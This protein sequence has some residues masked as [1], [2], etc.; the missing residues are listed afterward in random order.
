[1]SFKSKTESKGLR[2]ASLTLASTYELY[3]PGITQIPNRP[4]VLPRWS[5][6]TPILI[7]L[8]LKKSLEADISGGKN[9]SGP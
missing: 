3:I 8:C 4:R 7:N 2:W 1:M 5:I 9:F 6:G